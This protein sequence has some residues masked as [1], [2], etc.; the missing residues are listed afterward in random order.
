ML[1][2]WSDFPEKTFDNLKSYLK[3]RKEDSSDQVT[4]EIEY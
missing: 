4:S 1:T 2:D 3:K